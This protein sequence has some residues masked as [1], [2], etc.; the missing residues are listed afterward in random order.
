MGATSKMIFGLTE[1][2]MHLLRGMA[3]AFS[4]FVT[5]R[6]TPP[7]KVLIEKAH[8][9]AIKK[10]IDALWKTVGIARTVLMDAILGELMDDP[11]T[12][13]DV[14]HNLKNH[15]EVDEFR[16]LDMKTFVRS[17]SSLVEAGL[18]TGDQ[19]KIW[20]LE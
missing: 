19:N 17:A 3:A 16:D 2:G 18:I 6:D 20:I 5:D 7:E 10:R 12:L 9:D 11:K 4:E 1:K 15:E 14:F 8:V 13:P